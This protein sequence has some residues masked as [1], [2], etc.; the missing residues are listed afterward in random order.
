MST[1]LPLAL[2]VVMGA[3]LALGLRHDPKV[4]PS[5]LINRPVPVFDLPGLAAG[6]AN[7]KSDAFKGKGLTLINVF[8]S[9]CVSCREEHPLLMRISKDARF[10]LVGLNWKDSNGDAAKY[11]ETY[12]NPYAQI[13]TDQSGRA[14]IDLGVSGAPETF[15]VDAQGRV[16]LR[17]PGALTPEIWDKQIEPLIKEAEKAS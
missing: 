1:A 11:L 17:I 8:A 16:R 12:G 15:A 2:F 13:G 7:L 4:L 10:K 14:G 3:V 6:E 5:M 9:W